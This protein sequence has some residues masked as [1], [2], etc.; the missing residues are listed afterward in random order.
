M[1]FSSVIFGAFALLTTSVVATSLDF[2][3]CTSEAK[4]CDKDAKSCTSLNAPII[5]PIIVAD[6]YALI[7]DIQAEIDIC[8]AIKV[9]PS[10]DVQAKIFLEL[11]ALVNATITACVDLIAVAHIIILV[12]LKAQ[13][14]VALKALLTVYA[15]LFADLEVCLGL[16]AKL[17]AALWLT[18]QAELNLCIS[19]YAAL[20]IL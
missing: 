4:K 9:G 14:Q 2:S 16:E 12:D 18:L 15:T 11:Q 6:I 13:V 7:A 10:A 3:N 8:L 17:I 20:K 5:Y 1:R 19:A